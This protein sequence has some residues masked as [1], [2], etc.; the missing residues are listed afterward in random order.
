MDTQ[1]LIIAYVIAAAVA[2]AA[3]HIYKVFSSSDDPCRNCSGCDL[4]R[5]AGS[6]KSENPPCCEKK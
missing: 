1:Y 4:K 6:S 3:W 5:S 2:Y